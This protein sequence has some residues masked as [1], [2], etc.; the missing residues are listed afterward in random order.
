MTEKA[1]RQGGPGINKNVVIWYNRTRYKVTIT[2]QT[3]VTMGGWQSEK[4][5]Q[6]VEA[7]SVALG[8]PPDLLDALAYWSHDERFGA[9][10]AVVEA[11]IWWHIGTAPQPAQKEDE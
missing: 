5:I 8:G 4:V 7:F 10:S 11:A 6:S 9:R 2:P 3:I 1:G